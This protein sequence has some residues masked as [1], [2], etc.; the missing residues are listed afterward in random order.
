MM[1]LREKVGSLGPSGNKENPPKVGIR[2]ESGDVGKLA[3][4]NLFLGGRSDLTE[5]N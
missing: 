5:V 2:K 1:K 4:P 3:F